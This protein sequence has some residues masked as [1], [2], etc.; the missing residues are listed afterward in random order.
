MLK[1]YFKKFMAMMQDRKVE[2]GRE[3]VSWQGVK[4]VEFK[5][6]LSSFYFISNLLLLL[7]D[8]HSYILHFI[9]FVILFFDTLFIYSLT[10]KDL[11][12]NIIIINILAML[13]IPMIAL[14]LVPIALNNNNRK[15]ECYIKAIGTLLFLA[16]IEYVCCYFVL[17][18]TVFDI[19]YIFII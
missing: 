14:I 7:F 16:V 2:I 8:V 1:K 10:T 9:I 15:G 19:P 4:I 18:F 17:Y 11:I 6:D 5:P 13:H 3:Y 12:R